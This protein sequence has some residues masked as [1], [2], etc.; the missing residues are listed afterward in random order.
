M[1]L[2]ILNVHS[3]KCLYIYMNHV[4]RDRFMLQIYVFDNDTIS[5]N[6]HTVL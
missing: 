4:L 5:L 6:A 2:S 3:L 1:L